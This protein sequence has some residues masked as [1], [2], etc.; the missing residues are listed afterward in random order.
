MGDCD[1]DTL[2]NV[3]KCDYDFDYEDF[4]DISEAAKDFIDK[5]LIVNKKLVRLQLTHYEGSG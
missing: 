3:I 4:D 2:T 1:A 5:L